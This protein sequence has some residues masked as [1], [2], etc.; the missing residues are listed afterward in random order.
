MSSD[1]K[2]FLFLFFFLAR[3]LL[4]GFLTIYMNFLSFQFFKHSLIRRQAFTCDILLCLVQL[5]FSKQ[6]SCISLTVFPIQTL[7]H[8]ARMLKVMSHWTLSGKYNLPITK[9]INLR[10]LES[11][12][13]S[14]IS[15]TEFLPDSNNG[16]ECINHR[17]TDYLD[18][19]TIS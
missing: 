10:M 9:G 5:G 18:V 19:E 2:K 12:A 1:L 17:K 4:Y 7:S 8:Y 11:T 15:I 3:Y 16:K 13:L 14:A 6:M